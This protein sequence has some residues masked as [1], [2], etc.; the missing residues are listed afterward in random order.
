MNV[1]L[2]L[3]PPAYTH[4]PTISKTELPTSLRAVEGSLLEIG[5]SVDQ[6]LDHFDLQLGPDA[7]QRLTAK[8]DDPERYVFQTKLEKTLRLTPVFASMHGLTN[9]RPPSCQVI[10]YPDRAADVAI[11]SPEREISLRPND[12]NT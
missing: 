3:V 10:V 6:P 12:Q 4:S 5:F 9:L 7:S 8:K 11:I 2:K 1:Q